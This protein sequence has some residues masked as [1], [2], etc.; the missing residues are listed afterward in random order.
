M[1]HSNLGWEHQKSNLAHKKLRASTSPYFLKEN[2]FWLMV[3][4]IIMNY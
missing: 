4:E 1:V 2:G 3:K